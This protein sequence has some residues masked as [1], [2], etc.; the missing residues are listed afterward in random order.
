M[1]LSKTDST[2]PYRLQLN[3]SA[4]RSL[5]HLRITAYVRR[6]LARSVRDIWVN[7]DRLESVGLR[8]QSFSDL[9]CSE[10]V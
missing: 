2:P 8:R 6:Q 3:K 9:Q 1:R 7:W 10:I 5:G 4:V